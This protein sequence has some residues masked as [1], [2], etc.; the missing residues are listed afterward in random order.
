[1]FLKFDLSLNPSP[2]RGTCRV[3][4]WSDAH[5]MSCCVPF[6]LGRKGPETSGGIEV[7]A[8]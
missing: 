1:M 4:K 8:V 6:L 3:K 5:K 2:R 7:Y